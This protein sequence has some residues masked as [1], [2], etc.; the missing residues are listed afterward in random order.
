MRYE[1][2]IARVIYQTIL[3]AKLVD[4]VIRYETQNRGSVHVHMLWWLVFKDKAVPERFK[5]HIPPE[6]EREFHL[7]IVD[8]QTGEMK[9]RLYDQDLLDY[10]NANVWSLQ[11]WFNIEDRLSQTVSPAERRAIEEERAANEA[12]HEEGRNMHLEP[13]VEEVL[14]INGLEDGPYWDDSCYDG[15]HHYRLGISQSQLAKTHPSSVLPNEMITA[16]DMSE[17]LAREVVDFQTH[18]C[19]RG[20]CL[21][22][23]MTAAEC[24]KKGL[25]Y[26]ASESAWNAMS[27]KQAAAYYICKKKFPKLV[28]DEERLR[29][30]VMVNFDKSVMYEPVRD[31]GRVNNYH[32]MLMHFWGSNMDMQILH[33]STL[34]QMK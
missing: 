23:R 31:H 27:D 11:D 5:V 8:E 13:A 15:N 14:R 3:G 34:S 22:R 17:R 20:I 1:W 2:S 10:T 12:L 30:H 28:R 9:Q 19:K 33:K 6:M 7:V 4:Y 29:A 26:P 24:R 25:P 16:K 32:P 21:V 18:T